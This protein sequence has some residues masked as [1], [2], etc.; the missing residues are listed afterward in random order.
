[1]KK[2]TGI[3]I[4][5]GLFVCML[6]LSVYPFRKW[7]YVYADRYQSAAATELLRISQEVPVRQKFRAQEPVLRAVEIVAEQVR[8]HGQNSGYLQNGAL[9]V[10]IIENGTHI[11]FEKKL[12]CQFFRSQKPQT[13]KTRLKLK[14]NA[15]YILELQPDK[16]TFVSVPVL[17]SPEH[18][19]AS[20]SSYS[21]QGKSR[22][23]GL[24]VSFVYGRYYHKLQVLMIWIVLAVIYI[25]AVWII[26]Q[27]GKRAAVLEFL[28]C[29]KTWKQIWVILSLVSAFNLNAYLSSFVTA[30]KTWQVMYPGVIL[31]IVTGLITIWL[32]R[33]SDWKE[34]CA[35]VK[36]DMAEHKLLLLVLLGAAL[37]RLS[38]FFSIPKWD[39]GEYY[40]RLGTACRNYGFTFGSFFEHFRLCTH[41]NLGFSFLM[42]I[43]E[44][45][46][47]RNPLGV[48]VWNLI[49]TLY[50]IFCIYILVL[51]CWIRDGKR[52][53]ALIAWTASVT[54]VFLGTSSYI[55]VDYLLA[56]LFLYVLYFEYRQAYL[57]MA[58]ATLLLS[59]TKETG[60]VVTLGYFGIKILI[61][62]LSGQGGL[63][64][65]ILGCMQKVYFWI[66]VWAGAVYGLQV[67]KIGGFSTWVQNTDE[68]ASAMRWSDTGMNCFGFQPEYIIYKLKQFLILNFAWVLC[69]LIVVSLCIL[70]YRRLFCRRTGKRRWMWEIAGVMAAFAMSGFFYVTYTLARYNILFALLLTVTGCCLAYDALNKKIFYGVVISLCA[71]LSV[72]SFWNIDIVSGRVFQAV[73]VGENHQM[74]FSSYGQ[75]YYGDGLVTNYQYHWLD[76]A[77]NQL[78]GQIQ[79]HPDQG[80]ILTRQQLQ[81]TQINGNPGYYEIGWDPQKSRRVIRSVDD[82]SLKTIRTVSTCDSFSQLPFRY[83][84][85]QTAGT[86]RPES[87]LI[88]VPYYQQKEADYLRLYEDYCYI[89]P[90][91]SAKAYGG[92]VGYYP[93]RRKDRYSYLSLDDLKEAVLHP[94]SRYAETER[95]ETET[96]AEEIAEEK[97]AGEEITAEK[98]AAEKTAA[99]KMSEQDTE[100]AAAEKISEQDTEKKSEHNDWN[101]L[102]EQYL[103]DAG[104]SLGKV[105]EYYNYRMQGSG[106]ISEAEEGRKTIRPGDVITMELEVYTAQKEK[107]STEFVGTCFNNKYYN[108]VIGNDSL[109]KEAEQALIGAKTGS[110]VKADV[111]IPKDYPALMEYAGQCLHF[112][113]KPVKITGTYEPEDYDSSKAKAV[114]NGSLKAVWDFYRDQAMKRLLLETVNSTCS[115][116]PVL[117][118]EELEAIE[119]YME[120]YLAECSLSQKE[121]L[122]EYLQVTEDEYQ[123]LKTALAKA[124]IRAGQVYAV[125]EYGMYRFYQRGRDGFR[126][127]EGLYA[128]GWMADAGSIFMVNT[129]QHTSL[130]I[131]YYAP[132]QMKGE[133]ISI[134]KDHRC[135]RRQTIRSGMNQISWELGNDKN[136][137]YDIRVSAVFNPKQEGSGE[138][139]RDLSVL[140]KGMELK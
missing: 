111:R 126:K 12:P 25:A 48:Y 18:A 66:A 58:F 50:A 65:R 22:N 36:K 119:R 64:K 33:T 73:S 16:D 95:S 89:A 70:I 13:I 78:L 69:I 26:F 27:K 118:S 134:W 131:S 28:S 110:V 117:V 37:I 86:I 103:A 39:A 76:Q 108:I 7:N 81:G 93:M 74:L 59:Q 97:I 123:I 135:I 14:Q 138:D 19:S 31:W 8:Y 49:L 44:F 92:A 107:L 105:R 88:F 43:A 68:E 46:T 34:V 56:L 42:G 62:F 29:R 90:K 47:P 17:D 10:R 24:A 71:L 32:F 57:L 114:Y 124:A 139:E 112:V 23:G 94:H 2:K 101:Q 9:T 140:I 60:V 80:L 116:D 132:D 79:Y 113:M 41:S 96:A 5:L 54:P 137:Q 77:Y 30:P 53:A 133:H 98:T 55:N 6:M 40:Y 120:Y 87:Y 72:Q 136:S 4:L 104:W 11:L 21:Y 102:F 122:E 3:S 35:K 38:M 85:Y 52:C 100:K 63:W 45:L 125:D 115:Y 84:G 15:D 20:L 1:M 61:D 130:T 83:Y 128:D 121:F 51:R 127:G 91:Q 67:I 109:L 75:E 106:R 129:K 99:E 82:S